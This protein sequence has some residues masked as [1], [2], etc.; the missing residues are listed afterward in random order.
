MRKIPV[1]MLLAVVAVVV[2]VAC[3]GCGAGGNYSSSTV[4]TRPAPTPV[5]PISTATNPAVVAATA[6][7][8]QDTTVLAEFAANANGNVNP[9]GTLG[10]I[11]CLAATDDAAGNVYASYSKDAI[12]FGLPSAEGV[13]GVVYE[14]AAATGATLRSILLGSYVYGVAI[15]VDQSENL[16]VLEGNGTI[17][18]YGPAQSGSAVPI[19]TISPPTAP[20]GVLGLTLDAAG[21]FYVVYSLSYSAAVGVT[22]SVLMYPA[23]SSGTVTP[24]VVIPT[25]YWAHGIAL[26]AAGNLYI[27]QYGSA[28]P[29]GVY[30]FA[31]GSNANSVP[32][33]SISGAATGIPSSPYGAWEPIAVD[34][35]GNVFVSSVPQNSTASILV[36]P[37]SATGNVAPASTISS[38][39]L[40]YPI[41]IFLR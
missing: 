28:I 19:R 30:V 41:G 25:T 8:C 7:V 2:A 14:F 3:G 18:E 34:A 31:P 26:D 33:R 20:Y 5:V 1:S 36:F 4:P 40:T 39:S 16:Y 10:P 27:A 21:N 29:A 9:T 23:A 17:A 11:E 38:T 24:T 13:V 22:T 32:I 37:S 6:Y 35:G 15:A 12:N